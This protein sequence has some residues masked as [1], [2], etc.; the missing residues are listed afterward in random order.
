MTIARILYALMN[1]TAA[2][3]EGFI[4]EHG[5]GF[6]SEQYAQLK[7]APRFFFSLNNDLRVKFVQLLE[8]VAL[9]S[10]KITGTIY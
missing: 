10:E 7:D 8:D 9:R 2:D 6:M 4:K 3:Y 1:L 5:V